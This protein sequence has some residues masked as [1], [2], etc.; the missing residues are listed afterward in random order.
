MYTVK[1][2]DFIFVLDTLYIHVRSSS[3]VHCDYKQAKQG[4][5]L[6]QRHT[7]GF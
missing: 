7:V 4:V 3:N 5:M 2:I 1:E 6:K